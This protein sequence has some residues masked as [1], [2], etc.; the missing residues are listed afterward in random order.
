ML[1]VVII[2][3]NWNGLKDTLEC[4]GSVEKLNL[5]GLNLSIIVVDNAS[6]D[7]SVRE[8]SKRFPMLTVIKNIQNVGFAEGNN[9]AIR[10]QKNQNNDYIFLV[11]NDTILEKN[12]LKNLVE[13]MEKDKKTGIISP[14]IYFAKNFEYHKERYK[15]NERGKIIWYAGGQIDWNNVFCSH[16]GVDDV[17]IG[18]YEKEIE[19][20]FVSGCGMLIQKEV[21]NEIGLFDKNFFM[22]QEDVDFCI[23]AKNKGWKIKYNPSGIM[24]H[25]NAS[26][27]G[28]PG[29]LLHEYYQTRNRLILG[30]KYT[31]LRTKFALFRESMRMVKQDSVKREAILDFYLRRLGRGF[32]HGVN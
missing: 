1:K 17:D 24:W 27:S 5:D 10:Q 3:V 15:E 21:I 9:I 6:S 30:F 23:R 4:L 32:Y 25:K 19:T 11:N 29:S 31:S 7:N 22:Y 13:S 2:I 12:C 16:R 26:S 14:K 20:D 18:Q 8:I 28:K